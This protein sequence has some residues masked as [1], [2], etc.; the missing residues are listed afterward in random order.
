M[1][2]VLKIKGIC[3]KITTEINIF[4][5]LP[6]TGITFIYRYYTIIYWVLYNYVV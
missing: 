4:I 2:M 1:F 3:F 5:L 6:D